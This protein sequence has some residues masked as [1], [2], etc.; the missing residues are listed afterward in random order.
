MQGNKALGILAS[1][2]L[3]L[4]ACKLGDAIRFVAVPL[5][6]K[7]TWTHHLSDIFE[8][9]TLCQ[10]GIKF[11]FRDLQPDSHWH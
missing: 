7:Q 1:S 4:G 2:T 5:H 9:L 10:A 11:W 3:D 8:L 6:E